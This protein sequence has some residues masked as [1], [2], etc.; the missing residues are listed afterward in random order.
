[1]NMNIIMIMIMIIIPFIIIII[2]IIL[3]SITHTIIT[4]IIMPILGDSLIQALPY[5]GFNINAVVSS[6]E[7][8][9][10][11]KPGFKIK[12]NCSN[13]KGSILN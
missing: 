1:M 7:R 10:W 2:I 5:S 3:T 9:G 11:N 4:I 8:L 13:P 6:R 12:E